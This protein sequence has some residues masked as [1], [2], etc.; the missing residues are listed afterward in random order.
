VSG[1]HSAPTLLP[2][3]SISQT[4]YQLPATGPTR[5]TLFLSFSLHSLSP[6]PIPPLLP[7]PA[8]KS[9][10]C[11]LRR[12]RIRCQQ[13][14]PATTPARGASAA[15]PARAEASPAARCCSFTI[16][17]AAQRRAEVE[18]PYSDGSWRGT[19]D[20]AHGG[21]GGAGSS[22]SAMAMA[23]AAAGI[24]LRRCPPSFAGSAAGASSRGRVEQGRGGHARWCAAPPLAPHWWQ[25]SSSGRCGPLS[26]LRRRPFPHLWL[27]PLPP[28]VR[29][30]VPQLPLH[31]VCGDL[32]PRLE[33]LGWR[34]SAWARRPIRASR[35]N[36]PPPDLTSPQPNA[37]IASDLRPQVQPKNGK[38]DQ[39][40][41]LPALSSPQCGQSKTCFSHL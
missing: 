16:Y 26:H 17:L 37:T 7:P 38:S 29:G 2:S 14:R 28:S 33:R 15:D 19:R 3:T 5:H 41:A 12:R 27:R 9:L 11:S 20:M 30:T 1:P 4:P 40:V 21:P 10:L 34:A 8:L 22:R 23:G 24:D 39:E 6:P 36:G 25:A 31:G 32:P 35:Q 13:L 18:L